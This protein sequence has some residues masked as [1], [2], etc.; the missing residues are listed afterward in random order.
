MEISMF[1]PVFYKKLAPIFAFMTLG[2][3]AP[4]KI[5]DHLS[6]KQMIGVKPGLKNDLG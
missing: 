2:L 1:T 3:V 6:K 5:S 4:M